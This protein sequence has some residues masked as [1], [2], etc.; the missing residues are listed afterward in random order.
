LVDGPEERAVVGKSA[1][2]IYAPV[3][4]RAPD[5]KVVVNAQTGLPV[6]NTDKLDSF[7][8]QNGYYGS[9]FYDYDM[10]FSNTFSYKNFSLSFSLDFRHGG[11]MYSETADQVLFTGN[12][13]ATTYNDRKP[14]VVPNSVNAVVN[15]STTTYVP[16][17]TY[18]GNTAPYNSQTDLTFEYY[19]SATSPASLYPMTIF[20]R[21]FLKLRDI[22][23]SYT[24]PVK[25]ASKIGSSSATIG[26]FARNILLW[27][28]KSNVYI[29]PE[30]TNL[31]NDLSSDYGEFATAPLSQQ[32]GLIVKCIF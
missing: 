9:A 11:V 14:F 19:N 23:F 32:Y 25:W 10:G 8:N 17:T 2:S 30:A 1:A 6:V 5:G 21:S 12:G 27:T 7:G 15:G 18:V 3:A 4:Q 26:V 22:N 20:D 29:D 24:L 31:G 28:P 13:V 16:N